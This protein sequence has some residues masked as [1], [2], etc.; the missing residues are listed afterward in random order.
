MRAALVFQAAVRALARDQERDFL[1]PA[2]FR[3]ILRKDVHLPALA[4]GIA[5]VHA[6]QVASKKRRLVAANAAAN[7]H[8]DVPLVVRIFREQQN[9]E[10][11][12]ELLF[13]R[14]EVRELL[15]DEVAHLVVRLLGKHRLVLGNAA[16]DIL[17]HA[18]AFDNGRELRMLLVHALPAVDVRHRRRVGNQG[19]QLPEFVFDRLKLFEQE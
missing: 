11:A 1:E 12:I 18:K 3:G 15:L 16:R 5:A 13:L 9:R 2:D 4:L 7:L 10:L 17:V 19:L 14:H 6:E 8:D